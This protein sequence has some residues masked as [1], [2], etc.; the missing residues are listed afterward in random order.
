VDRISV[1]QDDMLLL[2]LARL[3]CVRAAARTGALSR[4]WRGLWA[5]LR[6][7]IFR[8]VSIPSMEAA[9]RRVSRPPPGL[10]LLDIRVPDEKPG[11]HA[12]D[13]ISLLCAAALLEPKELVF[14]IPSGDIP[15]MFFLRLPSDVKFPALE[16]LSLSGFHVVCFHCLLPS[17]PRLRVLRVKFSKQWFH[18]DANS[19]MSVH[20][21]S[22]QELSVEAENVFMDDV[23]IV[24]PE[25][26]QLAVSL[27]ASG[28]V[29]I[30]V[31]APV[32]EKLSWQWFYTSNVIKFGLWRIANF[33]L[34]TAER[35]EELPSLHIYAHIVCLLSRSNSCKLRLNKI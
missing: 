2:I 16:T 5:S 30:S 27:K 25:L 18:K 29:K 17:C 13:V 35:Q 8:G 26:K 28:P 14:N 23:D 7:I 12:A 31:S 34:H 1:L 24:A 20:S 6:E 22:L 15:P 32:V 9:L 19:F 21:T 3:G 11:P 4:R 10:S 33:R